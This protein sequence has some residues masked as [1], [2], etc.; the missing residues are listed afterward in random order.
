MKLPS[1]DAAI[2]DMV[3]LRDYCLSSTHPRGRHKARVFAD[4]LGMGSGDAAFLREALLRAALVEDVVET[5]VDTYGQRYQL[6]VVISRCGKTAIVRS[7]WI[8]LRNENVP[9]LT[10]CYVL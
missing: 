6:D 9:R 5:G 4:A 7:A 10:T 2:V 3:K 8:V 1:A